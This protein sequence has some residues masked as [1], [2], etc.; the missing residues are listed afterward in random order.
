MTGRRFPG[1]DVL[2][3][4]PTWDPVT[5]GVVLRRLGPRPPLRFFTPAEEATARAL[6]DRLLALGP[7]DD[8]PVFELV[9]ERLAQGET[10]GWHLESM[11]FDGDAWKATLAHL[12]DDAGGSFAAL[13][14]PAQREVLQRVHDADRW[15]DLPAGAVWSLW[16]RYACAAFYSHPSAWNEIGF[17]GP[18][19]P[20][21]YKAL[22][23]DARE[24]WEV[25]EVDDRNPQPWAERVEAARRRHRS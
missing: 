22:G 17:G 19:Y 11:P 23:L 8:V 21:G 2:D 20:R 12:D 18:A 9:D 4:A 25:A 16:M 3:Q 1:F 13:D 24:P 6:L 10:D 14:R 15:H 7:D 5:T